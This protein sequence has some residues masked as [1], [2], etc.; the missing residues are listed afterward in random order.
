MNRRSMIIKSNTKLINGPNSWRVSPYCW[1]ANSI[2]KQ[3]PVQWKGKPTV[4]VR[5]EEGFC[6]NIIN[7][8][9]R[10]LIILIHNNKSNVEGFHLITLRF[11][12][13]QF[14]SQFVVM[15]VALLFLLLLYSV[16]VGKRRQRGEKIYISERLHRMI[17]HTHADSTLILRQLWMIM[18]HHIRSGY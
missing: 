12:T 4:V 1:P 15:C 16:H 7:S 10:Q 17:A 6:I 2:G 8:W 18:L 9:F 11:D 13:L 5:A 3:N 14:I